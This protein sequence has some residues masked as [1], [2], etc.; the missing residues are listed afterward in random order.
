[1]TDNFEFISEYR[2]I[3]E[4][5]IYTEMLLETASSVLELGSYENQ[6]RKTAETMINKLISEF[7]LQCEPRLDLRGKIDFLY[8]SGIID[9]ASKD[10]YHTMRMEGNPGSHAHETMD[11]HASKNYY[12]E[13]RA[14]DE[15][16]FKRLY[17]E[18]HAFVEVYMPKAH[19]INAF[20]S[21]PSITPSAVIIED[22]SA[23]ESAPTNITSNENAK[24]MLSFGRYDE[25]LT[26]AEKSSKPKKS[27]I[28][29]L[30]DVIMI[31][32][33]ATF[34]FARITSLSWEFAFRIGECGPSSFITDFLDML[35][36][37][38]PE[39]WLIVIG[40]IV[41]IIDA[42]LNRKANIND[43]NYAGRKSRGVLLPFIIPAIL[44]FLALSYPFSVY[45]P[46]GAIVDTHVYYDT[47]FTEEEFEDYNWRI[48]NQKT[49]E[50]KCIDRGSVYTTYSFKNERGSFTFRLPSNLKVNLYGFVQDTLNYSSPENHQNL[51]INCISN[52]G[53]SYDIYVMI[54]GN[55][56]N[57]ST[58]LKRAESYYDYK[59]GMQVVFDVEMNRYPEAISTAWDG[60]DMFEANDYKKSVKFN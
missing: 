28:T 13:K 11:T 23:S 34:A 24:E 17:V 31:I 50:L 55:Q 15:N 45:M 52:S 58:I 48:K 47:D 20:N 41:S 22:V 9:A 18:C 14:K 30:F 43:S 21:T 7:N 49:A 1:M 40:L 16:A 42:N 29:I 5:A 60:T 59:S 27:G 6:L 46:E 39:I 8:K 10:N 4:N 2:N 38:C 33:W 3:Y 53:T 36:Y 56:I 35:G 25:E 57:N 32:W 19:G 12:D 44:I 54:N 51:R 26:P 37:G